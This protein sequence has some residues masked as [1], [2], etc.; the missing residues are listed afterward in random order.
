MLMLLF[1]FIGVILILIL[2]LILI[3]IVVTINININIINII[4]IIIIIIKCC[5]RDA[6]DVVVSFKPFELS[7]SETIPP[8]F[9]STTFEAIISDLCTNSTIGT[10]APRES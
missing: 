4:N 3:N 9:F 2:I 6:C 1:M 5:Q 7:T 10:S 8:P